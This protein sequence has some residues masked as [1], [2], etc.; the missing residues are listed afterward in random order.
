MNTKSKLLIIIGLIIALGLGAFTVGHAQKKDT[1]NFSTLFHSGD[2]QAME[3]IVDSY[4]EQHDESQ[5]VLTQGQWGQYYA[6]LRNAVITGNAPQ[7]GITHTTRLPQMQSALTTLNDTKAGNLLEMAGI[8][9]ED[10]VDTLWEAGEVDGDRY[11]VPL[12]THMW[13]FWYNRDIF[14]EA[15]LDPDNP[16]QRM[17]EFVEAANAIREEGYYAFHPA[18]DAEPRKLSRAWM[19]F[20]WQKGGELLNENMTRAT[21]NNEKGLEA[22]EFLVDIVQERDWNEPGTNGFNQFSSGELGMFFAGNWMYWTA[23]ESEV[24]WDFAYV[25]KFFD[26]RATWGNS[27]NLVIPKQADGVSDELLV[28]TAEALKWIN[29]NS[30]TWGIYGGHIPAY[31]PA[32]ES[33]ELKQSDTWQG[34]LKEFA[35]MANNGWMHY[36]IRHEN[37][38]E[39]NEAIQAQIQEAYNGSISPERALETAEENV[40]DILSE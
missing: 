19:I 20:Y 6:Q 2:A 40:N 31:L 23:E 17:D 22:L 9:G 30:H 11:M 35:D 25:P 39:I 32:Q 36:P 21:F 5:I 26:E 33:E 24:N 1:I 37:A 14:K 27:H 28:E 10:Y 3:R 7:L 18:E 8:N 34:A 4:N 38:S 16:P 15:G 29:E 12:D 13:G